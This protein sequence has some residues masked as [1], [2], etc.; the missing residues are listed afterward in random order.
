MWFV[1]AIVV[2]LIISVLVTWR[3][4][5][6]GCVRDRAPEIVDMTTD[7]LLD[8]MGSAERLLRGIPTERR[9]ADVVRKLCELCEQVS[10]ARLTIEVEG[11]KRSEFLR[12]FK[13]D[14][15]R[16]EEAFWSLG[17]NDRGEVGDAYARLTAEVLRLADAL[18]PKKVT[19]R[20]LLAT[21]VRAEGLVRDIASGRAASDVADAL[22]VLFEEAVAA[23]VEVDAASSS[24]EEEVQEFLD[25]VMDHNRRLDDAVRSLG[26]EERRVIEESFKRFWWEINRAA[27]DACT[28]TD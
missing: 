9:P 19:P 18:V 25:E 23:R 10:G 21:M 12:Y 5:S 26:E 11:W 24:W 22:D 1:A 3:H 4:L 6:G 7:E 8:I 20:K 27:L 16:L 2:V 14:R 15:E 28:R 13:K 17:A